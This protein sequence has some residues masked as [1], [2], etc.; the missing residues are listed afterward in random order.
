MARKNF[1][2]AKCGKVYGTPKGIVT[3]LRRAHKVEG[4]LEKNVLHTDLCDKVYEPVTPQTWHRK[5]VS[6][7]RKAKDIVGNIR[8]KRPHRL[9]DEAARRYTEGFADGMR[10]QMAKN[11][12]QLDRRTMVVTP[13]T[14][15]LDVPVILRVPIVVGKAVMARRE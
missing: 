9:D 14:T 2:C 3:H 5:S 6:K 12:R 7:K 11:K 1:K 4:V 15:H 10:S 8:A 13:K